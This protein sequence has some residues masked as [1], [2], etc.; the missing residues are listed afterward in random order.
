MPDSPESK[1]K[2]KNS[3][4]RRVRRYAQVGAGVGGVAMKAAGSRLLGFS[5]D[6]NKEAAELRAA[7]G[8]LKGPIMKVAQM[9]ATI[10]DLVPPEYA[11]ELRQLQ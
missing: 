5:P 2:E 3:R 10:P 8:G 11:D 7:L 9:L 6:K 1:S 4:L